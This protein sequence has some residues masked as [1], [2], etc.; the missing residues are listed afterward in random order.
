MK[1]LHEIRKEDDMYFNGVFWVVA[2]SVKDVLKGNFKLIGKKFP[3]NFEGE[4]YT[5]QPAKFMTHKHIWEDEFADKYN[6]VSFNYYPR[7]RCNVYQ[8]QVFVNLHSL[9]N[10]PKVIDAITK[11]CNYYKLNNGYEID[12]NDELQG[13]HYN[14]LLK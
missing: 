9:T 6:N 2:D 7:L 13:S 5:K 10:L 1:V 3:V 14:F 4:Y 11:E 12:N 8:G